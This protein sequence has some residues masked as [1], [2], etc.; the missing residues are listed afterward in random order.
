MS[1][2]YTK[3]TEDTLHTE[4]ETEAIKLGGMF[5]LTGEHA[6][7]WHMHAKSYTGLSPSVTQLIGALVKRGL[8]AWAKEK[9]V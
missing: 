4:P 1:K 5:T 6:R 9:K 7:L 8:V 3:H 2:K